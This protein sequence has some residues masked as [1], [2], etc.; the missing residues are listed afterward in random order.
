M[1]ERRQKIG[2]LTFHKC[3]N[4]GSYW[5]ALCLVQGLRARGHDAELLDHECRHVTLAELR[6][7]FQP[8]LPD[9]TARRDLGSY[10]RKARRFFQAF[11]GLPLSRPF[12]LDDAAALQAYDT[13]VVG[14][15]EVWN[16]AHPWYGG[17]PIFYGVGVNGPRLISYAASFGNYSCHWGLDEYWAGQLNR[18]DRMS[19]R[20]CNSY[21]LVRGATGREPEMVLDPVLQ[22]PSIATAQPTPV[23]G[24]YALVYGH[25]FPGWL[26]EAARRWSRSSG[27]PLL[28]VGYANDWTDAQRLDS[29]PLEFAQLMAG[30]SAVITNFFHGCV[31]ALLY[32][33]PWATAPS[34]Y[35]STKVR[36]LAELLGARHRVVDG[37]TSQRGFC[38][39]LDT[40]VLPRVLDRMAEQRARSNDFLDAALA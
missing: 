19:V 40:P 31:F 27:I 18:F 12:P 1:A 21:W 24:A 11:A 37:Q 4:Y 25:G 33:K 20:D 29:G 2:V 13:I 30:A 9:R 38:A 10:A 7:A 35:R 6:C 32:G 16:L 28:S 5:Q 14:S 34:D 17:K 15:D 8:Q 22:F 26:R 23:T 36:D 39:L 3:I